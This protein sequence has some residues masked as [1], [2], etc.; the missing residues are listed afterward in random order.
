[1]KPSVWLERLIAIC[2][3]TIID[4]G[5]KCSKEIN[6]LYSFISI[7]NQPTTCNDN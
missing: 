3:S 7:R 6:Y 4:E 2:L 5:E 1:M